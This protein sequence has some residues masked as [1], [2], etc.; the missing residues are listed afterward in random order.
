[1]E[2]SQLFIN[3]FPCDARSGK[4]NIKLHIR[5]TY[6]RIEIWAA[7]SGSLV[8]SETIM[9]CSPHEQYDAKI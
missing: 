6:F 3:Q 7:L 4:L 8:Y 2:P 9:L 1:M 5:H